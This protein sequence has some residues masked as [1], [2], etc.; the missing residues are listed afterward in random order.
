MLFRSEWF[1]D[2]AAGKIY[3]WTENSDDPAQ[4]RVEVSSRDFGFFINGKNDVFIQD[5]AIRDA[6]KNDI[7]TLNSNNLQLRDLHISGG[8]TG[9]YFIS[10]TDSSIRN[11]IIENTLSNGIGGFGAVNNLDIA[12][13]TINNAGNVGKCPKNSNG[14]ISVS[15]SRMNISGN[16]I[17]NSGYDGIGYYG[18]LTV[19]Q[20]NTIDHSCLVLGDCGGIYTNSAHP[21]WTSIIRHNKILN[22]FGNYDGTTD[23]APMAAG[24]YLDDYAHGYT[25]TNNIV[26]N[27]YFGIF[28]HTGSNNSILN[29]YVY[30]S[31]RW[32]FLLNET[33]TGVT[34]GT[35][36]GNVV[37]GNRFETIT[38]D[39]VAV[40][41]S[42][43][44][45]TTSFGTFNDN[46]YCHPNSL[47]AV[48]N[49]SIR[50]TL[51][52]WQQFSGQDM[53]SSETWTLCPRLD[54]PGDISGDGRISM[55]DAALVLKYTV[56]GMLTT[57]QQSQADMNGDHIIDGQDAATMAKKSLGLN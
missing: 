44:G 46:L 13:N 23:G 48:A 8:S 30:N 26:D 15:G 37:S 19:V 9:I 5:I 11:N 56:G 24:I 41:D 51:A 32:A 28:V 2:A 6:N 18:D 43:V 55:Y 12:H 21:E 17:T 29:N 31:R 38:N 49:K 33:S 54:T 10:L 57:A 1:F 45:D 22:S 16:T 40:F 14:G 36:H 35:V 39:P 53:G 7:Y 34:P 4:H 47:S 50:Y 25:V 42:R 3:L 27:A 52:G 20:D